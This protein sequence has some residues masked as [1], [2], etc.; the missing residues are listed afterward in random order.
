MRTL[1]LF[2]PIVA[3][4]KYFEVDE[5]RETSN[6][7]ENFGLKRQRGIFQHPPALNMQ[8]LLEKVYDELFYCV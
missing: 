8:G 1:K 5:P 3:S 7:T 4:Y 2:L 6:A